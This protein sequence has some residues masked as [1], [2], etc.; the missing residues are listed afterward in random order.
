MTYFLTGVEEMFKFLDP[1]FH[2]LNDGKIIRLTV[3]WVLRVLAVLGALGG[4]AWFVAILAFAH[5]IT[6]SEFPVEHSGAILAGAFLLSLMG[7]VLGY[8]WAGICL[9]RARSILELSDG[10]YTVIPILSML[11][12][13]NGELIFVTYSLIGL[14]GCLVFW[15]T[16]SNPLTMLPI[17]SHLPVPEIEGSG[18]V[19]GLEF[20]VFLLLIAFLGIVFFYA[21]AE[22]SIVLVEIASNTAWSARPVPGTAKPEAVPSPVRKDTFNNPELSHFNVPVPAPAPATEL[23]L[24]YSSVPASPPVCPNCGQPIEAGAGFCSECG[25]AVQ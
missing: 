4:V 17:Q 3:A 15:V 11:F 24:S 20:A 2:A 21:L 19:A 14:F 18:F 12:R 1:F 16:E 9:F 10:H 13:L 7:L 22:F 5:R 25:K 23:S 6:S 8:L